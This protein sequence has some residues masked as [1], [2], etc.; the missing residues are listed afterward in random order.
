MVRKLPLA[1]FFLLASPLARAETKPLRALII[2]G[3]CCH[4]YENQPKILSAGIQARSNVQVDVVWTDDKST[5]PY[6]PLFEKEDWAKG[7]DVIIHD[8]CAAGVKDLV[9]VQR[10][11][12]AHET[13]PAVNLHCAMHSY[14]TGTDDWFNFLG[15]QSSSHNWQK[16]IAIHYTDAEHPI[17]KGLSDWPTVN[18]ELYNNV[19]M[20]G[21]KPVAAGVQDQK[22]KEGVEA[23]V[24]Y[25]VA[26]TNEFGP[27]KTRIFST[28]IGHNN[29]TVADERYLDLVTRGLLWSCDKLNAEYLKPFN[30]KNEVTFIK[31]KPP[32]AAPKAPPAVQDGTPVV[33]TASSTQPGN[34]TWKAADGKDGTRWCASDASKPQWLQLEFDAPRALTGVKI[35]WEAKRAYQHKV[36]GSPDGKTWTL[37]VDATENKSEGT[38][39]HALNAKDVRYLKITC[40]A[41]S[42]GWVSIR[43][44][45]VKG[46]GIKALAPKMS[47]EQ[48]AEAK[49]S[50][51]DPNDPLKNEGNITPKITQRTPQEEAEILKDA[52]AADGFDMTLFAAPPAVN[53]PVFVS[54]SP[55]GALYVSSD[56]NGSVERKPHRGRIIRLRDTD[57]D[58]RADEV[59]EFVKDLDSPRGL[60][61][62]R[63][64]LYVV[65]PPDVSVYIDKNRTGVATE[66]KTLIRG[67]AFG[68][69]DR[70]AD[71]TTNGLSLGIDGWLYIAG[72]DFGFMD[73]EGTDGR[74]LQ[75]RGGGVIRFR[76]DGSGIE[77]VSRGT[78]N[79]LEVAVGPLMEMFARDNTNDGDGWDVRFHH[80]TGM[81]THGYPTLYKNFPDE[82]IKP[83]N[84]YGGGSG[85]GAV[86]LDEPGFGRW[87]NSPL[88]EDWG[89]GAL[90]RHNV[91]RKGSTYMETEKP[92]PFIKMTR[93][94]DAD[95]DAL[96]NVYQ[97]SW[98]GATFGWAG[99]EVGYIVRVTPK[100]FKAPAV[101][102][103]DKLE[104]AALVRLLES[105][106]HR[107][108][109]EAQR[110]LLSRG[111]KTSTQGLLLALAGDASKGLAQR[112][113]AL[114][115]VT[116]RN[117]SAP[118]L[119]KINAVA[120]LANDP[121]LHP[122]VLLAL[123]DSGLGASQ[124]SSS[125][126]PASV[127]SAGLKS[128]DPQTRL[129]AVIGAA[130]QR[131]NSLAPEIAALLDD[132]DEVIVHT[133]QR[134]LAALGAHEACMVVVDDPS[135]PSKKRES[136]LHSLRMMHT[137]DVVDGLV[138]RL[139]TAK[140]AEIRKGILSALCRL[141]FS[142]GKWEGASWGT[143]P[144]YR[145]PYYQPEAWSETDKIAGVLK[146]ALSGAQPEEAAF[147]ASE[148]NR[149]RIHFNEALQRL[150]ELA[151][152]DVK[153]IPDLAIQLASADTIPAE[154]VPLLI[155]AARSTEFSAV[156]ISQAVTALAKVDS[157]DGARA[158]LEGVVRLAGMSGA[159]KEREAGRN[160]F[161]NAP[162]LE[163]HHQMFEGI[164]EELGGKLA[165]WA[166]AVLLTLSSRKTG[167]PE[168]RE[169]S[170]KALDAG[171]QNA[172]R[173]AQILRA[174][175][176]IKHGPY[177]DKILASLDDPDKAVAD[178]AK[179]SAGKMRLTKSGK[180]SG[181]LIGTMQIKDIIAQVLNTKGDAA[182]GEQLFTRQTCAACHTVSQDQ[183]Q[184]GPYLGNIAQTYKRPDLAENILD[185]NKTIAQGFVTNVF[186]LKSG[187]VNM[188]FVVREG[189]DKVTVRNVA[190]QESTYEVKDIVKRETLPTSIMPP[191]LVNSLTVRE[192]ASLLDYLE[193]VSAKKQ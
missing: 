34:E 92:E 146:S 65:H 82:A 116:Q 21:G 70:P 183:A 122:Y 50:G 56:G 140:G 103:F 184:K 37:L 139:A 136:A 99:P 81:E 177:A 173:R 147:L 170:A 58:G 100:D 60:V 7:Y 74:H 16:P 156:V 32:A 85:T 84:D 138:K 19:K 168:S 119:D 4:D 134:S 6:F 97:A 159:S 47:A 98:K 13:V 191:G 12:K 114:Y 15:L 35:A 162:K 137:A 112:V 63:D 36:E 75:H 165:T 124:Q 95:V 181:P 192:F 28:T 110:T 33:I 24:N 53:Y 186:T 132:E 153:V 163:N 48:A 157:A 52:R 128:R 148:L 193:A 30:G 101:P 175:G 80:F 166:D 88:T 25:T 62:D 68:F 76:P 145:G 121:A 26:W 123:G 178:E 72:G 118:A 149:N 188:G 176:E 135:A 106:S 77:L 102:D 167:A 154:A 17:T 179:S 104:D 11:I 40:T 142:E 73:A 69:K 171:W 158:S 161:F 78:R 31:G 3:G 111:D 131:I 54:T 94:T 105:A 66:E 164:A 87:N 141:H 86:F 113:A 90:W 93:P 144:D 187:E 51:G 49:K 185:P 2:A 71:H 14:R 38:D 172:K 27:K 152:S 96:G 108:R 155:Q 64:R 182:L 150:L 1:L 41:T 117:V 9:L 143:R 83:L 67:I 174:A 160:A 130:R 29:A 125:V 89:T 22:S 189:S 169:L 190:S 43:E 10:I 59:K 46:D 91:T 42:G 55:D 23:P 151:K 18:E 5:T 133:V 120:A 45:S 115:G 129:N 127:F 20:H 109:L 39:E 107:T 126:V 180:D 79:I 8:E 57:G 44:V 61:W